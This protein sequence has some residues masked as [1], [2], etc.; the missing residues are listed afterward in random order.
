MSDA[1]MG[2]SLLWRV[3]EGHE[4]SVLIPH[5]RCLKPRA[6]EQKSIA[7]GLSRGVKP[8]PNSFHSNHRSSMQSSP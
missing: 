3:R 7:Q 8:L 1:G 6:A 4:S 2:R 5:P